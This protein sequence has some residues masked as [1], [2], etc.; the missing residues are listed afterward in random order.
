V[1]IVDDVISAGT[2]IRDSVNLISAARARATGVAVSLDRQE[3]GP[4]ERSAI[5]SVEEDLGLRVLSIISLDDLVAFLEADPRR[6]GDL[7]RVRAYCRAY[8][9][10]R[11]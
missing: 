11:R 3:R 9:A 5:Q 8:G 7:Q 2:S 6:A 1:L 4:D 10:N